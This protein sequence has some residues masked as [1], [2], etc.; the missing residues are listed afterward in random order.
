MVLKKEKKE[1]ADVILLRLYQ[2][3]EKATERRVVRPLCNI[4]LSLVSEALLTLASSPVALPPL[5]HRQLL[6]FL[7]RQAFERQRETDDVVVLRLGPFSWR[8][9]FEVLAC[10][11]YEWQKLR[12][13]RDPEVF[14]RLLASKRSAPQDSDLPTWQ[15]NE[16]L[17]VEQLKIGKFYNKKLCHSFIRFNFFG[18]KMRK[19]PY[20]V[21]IVLP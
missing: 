15:E 3:L 13:M 12:L 17:D 18:G 21:L 9:S 8:P 14:E 16:G 2:K 20:V 1:T 11:P 7:R 4:G 19:T 6:L 10:P 5:H